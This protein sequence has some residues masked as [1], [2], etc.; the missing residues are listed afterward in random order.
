M[1]DIPMNPIVKLGSKSTQLVAMAHSLLQ[2]FGGFGRLGTKK[3]FHQ[4]TIPCLFFVAEFSLSMTPFNMFFLSR[5]LLALKDW[6]VS[7]HRINVYM[8]KFNIDDSAIGNLGKVGFGGL[9]HDSNGTW[10]WVINALTNKITHTH[11]AS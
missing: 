2:Q 8:F 9:V 7:L 10:C 5:Q 4:T 6:S 3:F 1:H 11:K